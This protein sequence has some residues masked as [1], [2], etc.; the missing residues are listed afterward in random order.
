MELISSLAP[1]LL[2]V[3]NVYGVISR[4]LGFMGGSET[5][6]AFV[7][8]VMAFCKW[9]VKAKKAMFTIKTMIKVEMLENMRKA[10][11]PG[12]A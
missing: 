9:R 1:K 7:I 8:D 10:M 3:E 2:H 6:P 11:T 12:E 5:M 4:R